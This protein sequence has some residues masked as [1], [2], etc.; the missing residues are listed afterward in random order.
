MLGKKAGTD[1]AKRA[2]L[3]SFTNIWIG[4][5]SLA[6]LQLVLKALAGG[7]YLE[8]EVSEG[9]LSS[10]G[11]AVLSFSKAG[12]VTA[13]GGLLE[14]YHIAASDEDFDLYMLGC[15]SGKPT[16]GA[17]HWSHL[18]SRDPCKRTACVSPSVIHISRWRVLTAGQVVT[19]KYAAGHIRDFREAQLEAALLTVVEQI[20]DEDDN[21][22]GFDGS[23]LGPL[24][25]AASEKE[26]AG[27]AKHSKAG[28]RAAEDVWKAALGGPKQ[29]GSADDHLKVDENLARQ[30]ADSDAAADSAAQK[31]G[32]DLLGGL[33]PP[34][35]KGWGWR[36][37]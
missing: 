7:R 8:H 26:A 2:L 32:L 20:G 24:T 35:R 15:K 37:L 5:S 18:C 6:D 31:A 22:G 17:R 30:P 29:A 36:V 1:V 23:P 3:L 4:P 12:R 27:K 34:A 10:H 16:F 21:D 25:R 33:Q 9:N 19:L 14:G 13:R 28:F 11:N